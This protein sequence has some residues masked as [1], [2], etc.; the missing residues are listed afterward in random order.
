MNQIAELQALLGMDDEEELTSIS[1]QHG[2]NNPEVSKMTS[3]FLA[4]GL[5]DRALAYGAIPQ[6][7]SVP[8]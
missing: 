7:G 5:V 3:E 2:N 8:K 1:I 6:S 4:K